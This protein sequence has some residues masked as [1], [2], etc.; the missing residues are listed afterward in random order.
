MEEKVDTPSA[1]RDP[2]PPHQRTFRPG[3]WRPLL[4]DR[5]AIYEAG[6]LTASSELGEVR[7]AALDS[8]RLSNKRLA[9]L[10]FPVHFA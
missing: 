6:K 10:P 8:S 9:P 3:Q 7:E 2:T 1:A 4:S 5:S